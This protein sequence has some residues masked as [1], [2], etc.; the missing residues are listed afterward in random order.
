M[1]VKKFFSEDFITV[2]QY[3]PRNTTDK[4]TETRIVEFTSHGNFNKFL[5][6]GTGQQSNNWKRH[7]RE[8]IDVFE[9][10]NRKFYIL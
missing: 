5:L 2:N 6:K 9:L 1:L 3:T 7:K 8:Q 4:I 10:I